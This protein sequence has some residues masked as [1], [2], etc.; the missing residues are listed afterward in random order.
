MLTLRSIAAVVTVAALSACGSEAHQTI[1]APATGADVKFFNFGVGAPSVNFYGNDAKLTAIA[2]ST[3]AESLLG[4]AYGSAGNAGYY[5]A[6]VPGQYTFS[7]RITATTDNGLPIASAPAAVVDGKFYS[8]YVSGFYNTTTKQADAFVIEDVFPSTIDFTVANVRF[9]NA[10][11]N[12]SPMTL[13]ARSTVTGVEVPV[14]GLVAY[15]SGGVFVSLPTGA[16]DLSTRTAG[17]SANAIARTG[18]SFSGGR[19]YTVGALGDITIGGT[20]AAARAR[21]DNTTNR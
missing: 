17:S 16:Y 1:A 9:V 5:S 21:L 3:G 19:V 8:M 20:T 18:V 10:I 6:I 7:S 12:S 14:G 13:Y 11:G 15:K 2:S 4:T